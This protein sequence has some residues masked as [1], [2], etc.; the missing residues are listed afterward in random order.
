MREY[1]F[2]LIILFILSLEIISA[3]T[4]TTSSGLK[5]IV[6][7]E[8]S[9]I[10]P[11]KGK[12]VEVHYIGKLTDG[13]VFDASYNR[14]EPIEFILGA[15]QVIKGWDEGIALM[16]VGD[17]LTL[18]IPPDLAYG[19]RGAGGVIPPNATLI[20]DV[21]LISVSE[22]RKSFVDEMFLII[23]TQGVYEAISYYRDIKINKKDE[24]KFRE[25]ELNKLGYD[26]LQAGRI[27]DAIEIFKLNADEYP[28]SFNVYDSLAEGYMM[29]G[30]N[31][32]AVKFYEKSLEINPDNENG[33]KMLE[34]LRK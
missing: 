20:F 31:E 34:K 18:I 3:D 22:P 32:L 27:K 23:V 26:L 16:K 11:E 6:I 25:S 29:D 15:G 33:K 14:G 24:Y 30:Q 7:S 5:Y 10:M 21:E 8:G 13:T 28:D 1:I 17:K 12:S 9:G 19:E 2:A 4:V